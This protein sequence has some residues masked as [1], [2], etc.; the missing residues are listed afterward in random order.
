M[1]W[2]KVIEI[3]AYIV[4]G[5]SVIAAGVAP[6]TETKWDDKAAGLLSKAKK[7]LDMLALNFKK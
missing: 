1:D 4:A 2:M 3:A 7:L 6:L 5:A